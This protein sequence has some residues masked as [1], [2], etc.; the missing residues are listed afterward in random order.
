MSDAWCVARAR[1]LVG[2]LP[3]VMLGATRL[4]EAARCFGA[5]SLLSLAD[6]AQALSNTGLA[7]FHLGA[8]GAAA[9]MFASA[10]AVQ[11]NCSTARQGLAYMVF[12]GGDSADAAQAEL[13]QMNVTQQEREA[14]TQEDPV[15][16][17]GQMRVRSLNQRFML[18]PVYWLD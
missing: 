4:E 14:I 5:S 3:C 11:P 13:A 6:S 2:N 1:S 16:Q 18:Q 17:P 15:L 7:C 12:D 10:L 9:T 8:K